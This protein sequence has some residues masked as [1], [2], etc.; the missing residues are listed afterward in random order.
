MKINMLNVFRKEKIFS[1]LALF[2]LNSC[3]EKLTRVDFKMKY[4]RK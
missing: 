4:K 1:D 3:S 2:N